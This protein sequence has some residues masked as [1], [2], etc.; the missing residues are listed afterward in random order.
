MQRAA[1][2]VLLALVAGCAVATPIGLDGR[3]FLSATVTDRGA[4]RPLVAGT[5]IQLRFKEGRLGA[6]A[7]C[8]SMGGAYR[9][10]NNRLLVQD[11]AMT[12]MGCD[13][14][15][16]AQ[17]DWLADFLGSGPTLALAGNDLALT[18]DDTVIRLV[19]RAV[20]QPDRPIVGPLWTVD[21]LLNADIASSVP[22]GTTASLQ[23]AA[24]G[25]VAINTGCNTGQA[26]VTTDG[27]TISF[28]EIVLTRRACVGPEAQLE[29]AVMSVLG[30]PQ[31]QLQVDAATM[32]INTGQ[33]A[34]VL[35]AR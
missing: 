34:L 27:M 11:M 29:E 20:A 35:V 15:R 24:D 5:Q 18:L 31:A 13:G 30:A 25:T 33:A 22:E 16:H 28:G 32:T 3:T 1:L 17:D 21:S 12:A 14:P 9:V 7:G 19:D 6:D 10:E 2:L 26:V 4:D 8:N 23:F